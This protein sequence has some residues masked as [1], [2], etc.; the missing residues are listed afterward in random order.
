MGQYKIILIFKPSD[1][2]AI[3]SNPSNSITEL[4]T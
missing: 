2:R 4:R 3:F 1:M